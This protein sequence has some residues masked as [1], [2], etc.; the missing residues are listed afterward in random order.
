[1]AKKSRGIHVTGSSG[2]GEPVDI[3][4]D[5]HTFE[6]EIV[7][8]WVGTGGD[9]VVRLADDDEDQTFLN[10][11]DGTLLPIRPTIV[12]D[13]TTADDMIGLL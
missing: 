4:A 11:P 1:M 5:D 2:A 10:V 8:L 12:R 3:S 6:N 13:T 7:G 9:V